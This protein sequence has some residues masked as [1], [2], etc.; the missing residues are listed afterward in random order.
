MIL[1]GFYGTRKRAMWRFDGIKPKDT[2][3]LVLTR[4]DGGNNRIYDQIIV[5][6]SLAR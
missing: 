1:G 3:I 6:W 2:R 4:F 5:T